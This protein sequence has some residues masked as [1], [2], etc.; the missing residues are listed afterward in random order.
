MTDTSPRSRC[1]EGVPAVAAA[2]DDTSMVC[3]ASYAGTV[4]SVTYAPDATLT[5]ANTESRTCSLL[6]KGQGGAGTTVI[7]TKAFVST[8]NAAVGDETAITLSATAADLVVAEGDI[9]AWVSAHVGSTG[10]ADPGGLVTITFQRTY[11]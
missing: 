11:A 7:A 6:N 4:A 9:L 10:L 8:V 5:G 1:A 3:R 2:A